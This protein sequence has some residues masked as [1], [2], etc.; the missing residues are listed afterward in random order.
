MADSVFD[1]R[2][3]QNPETDQLPLLSYHRA[4]TE[5]ERRSILQR[6]LSRL[7]GGITVGGSRML[8]IPLDANGYILGD[9]AF[10]I[11]LVVPSGFTPGSELKSMDDMY[12]MLID[13][14]NKNLSTYCINYVTEIDGRVA[15]IIC[16][17]SDTSQELAEEETHLL[18]MCATTCQI[19]AKE[20]LHE[21][22][23]KIRSYL[24]EIVNG[25][26]NLPPT[27]E[28]LLS[29]SRY[30]EK[31]FPDSDAAIRVNG[32]DLERIDRMLADAYAA[33]I[34]LADVVI[35]GSDATEHAEMLLERLM[36]GSPQTHEH[37]L[38]RLHI[39][40]SACLREMCGHVIPEPVQYEVK[41]ILPYLFC[42]K[43]A[44]ALKGAF[45]NWVNAI[46]RTA[47]AVPKR[48]ASRY[49]I[50]SVVEFIDAN[51]HNSWLSAQ[52]VAE[53]FGMS[54]SLLSTRFK[55]EFGER[56]IDYLHRRRIERAVQVLRDTNLPIAE[57]CRQCG[58]VSTSTMNRA[59]KKYLNA[60][61]SSF[62]NET[63]RA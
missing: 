27:F 23:V 13:G 25:T 52:A 59:F 26:K 31:Y 49:N 54:P 44:Q 38:M 33:G 47:R 61:P 63:S 37:F 16:F 20:V 9:G 8:R 43:D 53:E 11:L 2:P 46:S 15:A 5:E 6:Y 10:A 42:A 22:N 51:A 28:L 29:A 18:D 30:S 24:S 12:R 39:F 62:R 32:A 7:L 1:K 45:L 35:S 21:Y 56:L 57:V 3:G 14:I 48:T 34:E 40:I 4:S 41:D 17:P 55:N 58:Y 60:A 36:A 50:Q 19:V